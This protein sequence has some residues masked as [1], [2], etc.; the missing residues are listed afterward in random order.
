MYSPPLFVGQALRTSL[1]P[2]LLE[3]RV[4]AYFAGHDHILQHIEVGRRKGPARAVAGVLL[5]LK[6]DRARACLRALLRWLQLTFSVLPFYP[7]SIFELSKRR[8]PLP[9]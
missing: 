2:L 8:L 5:C 4:D 9:N 3:H 1:L 6:L 7:P